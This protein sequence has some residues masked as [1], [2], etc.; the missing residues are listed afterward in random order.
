MVQ[1]MGIQIG[2]KVASTNHLFQLGESWWVEY[3]KCVP[4]SCIDEMDSE[5]EGR[6]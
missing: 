5:D 2:G 6:K 1:V 3:Q 4:N